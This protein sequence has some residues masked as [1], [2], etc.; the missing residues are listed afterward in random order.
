V[1]ESRKIRFRFFPRSQRRTPPRQYISRNHSDLFSR[2]FGVE[3]FWIIDPEPRIAHRYP[4]SAL[5]AR[6]SAHRRIDRIGSADPD[7]THRDL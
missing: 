1:Q 3:H 5:E 4:E 2:L 7:S 6:R